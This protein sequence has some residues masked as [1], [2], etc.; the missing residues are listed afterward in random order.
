MMARPIRE[1]P[2]LKGDD[3]YN[4]ELRRLMAENRSVAE[5]SEMQR[6]FSERVAEAKKHITFEW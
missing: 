3:A 2:V 4:F 6:R 5:R 1:T